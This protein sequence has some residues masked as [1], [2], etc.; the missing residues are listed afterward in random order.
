MQDLDRPLREGELLARLDWF[1]RLRW[2]FLLGL[3]LMVAVTSQLL[4]IPL[5]YPQILAVG[6]II[7]AYNIALSLTHSSFARRR[8]P[9]ITA[10]RIEANFQIGMDILALTAMIH[11]S[12]GV[13]NPFIFFYLFHA[14]IGSILLSRIEVWTHG[15]LAYAQFLL[16]VVLEYSEMLPHYSLSLLFA[17]PRHQRPFYLLAVSIAL[18]ITLFG[19]IYMSSSIAH[20]LR[21]R[22]VELLFTR[23]MLQRKSQDLEEANRELREKQGQLVQSEKLASLGQLSAGVAHEINNPIQFI[24][25]NIR[26]LQESMEGILPLLDRHAEAHPDFSLA[27]LTYPFFREHIKILLDD[28]YTGCL[29]IADI[30]RDLKKFARLDAGRMDETVDVN[31]VVRASL[32]LVQN[33]IKGYRVV[34]DLD[35]GLPAITGCTSKIEQVVVA[36]LINAAEALGDR[37]GGTIQVVTKP[38]DGGKGIRLSITDNGPGMAEETKRKVFDP[39]FTTKRQTGGT[40]LGLSVAYAIVNEH[41]GQV[42]VASTVGEGTTFTYHFPVK[43]RAG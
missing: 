38:D 25:G 29:R 30:V 24:Q 10:T 9:N 13:E 23:R 19:T 18:L 16:V 41:G 34:E 33:R 35:P 43:R 12:G 20:G 21:T 5:P 14:I 42:D 22:E 37:A 27:Q 2:G 6:G 11:F 28:M 32:R 40:G 8:P 39:F 17:S 15:C 31:E 26:I 3:S 36:N 4:G 7:F 1:I